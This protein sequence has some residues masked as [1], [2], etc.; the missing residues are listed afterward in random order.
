MSDTT[1]TSGRPDEVPA[2][3]EAPTRI[4]LVDDAHAGEL[5][6]LRRAAFVSEAQVYGDPNIPPLTQ[7]LHELREDMARDDVVTIGAWTG[8][9]LVG[10]IRVELQDGRATLG[11]LAVA[12][13]Q[14][15]RGLGTT[16]LFAILDHLPD[17][18]SEIWAFTGKDS[19]QNLAMYTKHGYEAQYDEA[20]GE[21]TYTYLRRV[22]HEV[23]ARNAGERPAGSPADRP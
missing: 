15:G 14:Q 12:P 5:L 21:L 3:S 23:N 17:D 2:R 4:A 6:T 11:R 7:T 10:S 13:D 20:A 1:A 16:L 18:V 19:Q 8:E 9:R 22:L